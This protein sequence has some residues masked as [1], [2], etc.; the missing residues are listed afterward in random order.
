MYK[1]SETYELKSRNDNSDDESLPVSGELNIIDQDIL[2][3]A[4]SARNS[5]YAL[6]SGEIQELY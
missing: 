1:R 5:D 2:A 6:Y 4:S 3:K